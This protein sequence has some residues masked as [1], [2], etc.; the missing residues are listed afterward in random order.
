MKLE[1]YPY[2]REA[3]KLSLHY[4]NKSGFCYNASQQRLGK[5]IEAIA[6]ADHLRAINTLVIGPKSVKLT[7]P[8]KFLEWSD[9]EPDSVTHRALILPKHFAALKDWYDLIIV[10]ESQAFK[11]LE[12]QQTFVF[13][14]RL[15]RRT[16]NI[17]FLSGTPIPNSVVDIYP[18]F[19]YFVPKKDQLGLTTKRKFGKYFSAVV[20]D[21]QY[22][23][24][25]IGH[26]R[27]NI[28]SKIMRKHFY[29]RHLRSEVAPELPPKQ[30]NE[31][32]L[33]DNYTEFRAQKDIDRLRYL[34]DSKQVKSEG[35]E[36]ALKKIEFP[37]DLAKELLG[38]IFKDGTISGEPVVIYA[39]HRR[40][41]NELTKR[42]RVYRP[43][44]VDGRTSLS[45]RHQ[46]VKDFQAGKVNLFIGQISAAGMAITLSR[47]SEIILAELTFDAG[48]I[49]Q[50]SDRC[51]A[52]GKM[53]PVRVSYFVTKGYD[54][55]ILDSLKLKQ[56]MM[57]AVVNG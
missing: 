32:I 25:Y 42:L 26:R 41:I 50:V 12:A 16:D 55:E 36:A 33:P 30:F 17:L 57:D 8:E 9:I 2:Q 37:V 23:A 15:R 43:V 1:L 21:T 51:I 18:C 54:R 24:M 48:A 47:A 22:G 31:I 29:F 6:V 4:I 35:Q 14:E 27:A 34:V 11:N 52:V 19:K 10:D 46:Y 38:E 49:S 7:W 56:K 5:M 53:D 20:R 39:W 44:V 3:V 13:F 28:L 40:V 45:K